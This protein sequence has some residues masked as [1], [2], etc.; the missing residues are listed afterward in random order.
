MF[1]TLS[2]SEEHLM[3][4]AMS[5]ASFIIL[6]QQWRWITILQQWPWILLL[7][8]ISLLHLFSID[9]SDDAIACDV[10]RRIRLE[11]KCTLMSTH[12]QSCY[13][14]MAWYLCFFHF[15]TFFFL[16]TQLLPHSPFWYCTLRFNSPRFRRRGYNL[17]IYLFIVYLATHFQ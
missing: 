16:F 3:S 15:H 14:F 5:V 11:F 13:T 17:F 12:F 2:V 10:A 4:P 1:L 8:L 7:P 6:S 9:C